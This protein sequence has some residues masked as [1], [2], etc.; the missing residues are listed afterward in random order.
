M[1]LFQLKNTVLCSIV[2]IS[3]FEMGSGGVWGILFSFFLCPMFI[4]EDRIL[5][6]NAYKDPVFFEVFY[7][8]IVA[9]R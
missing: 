1:I 7:G 3:R 2:E 5:Q 9:F 6:G 8:F 4:F